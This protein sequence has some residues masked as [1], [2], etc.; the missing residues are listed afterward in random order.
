[1]PYSED[2][3]LKCLAGISDPLGPNDIV[4]AGRLASL[5]FNKG[6]LQVVLQIPPPE[7]EKFF[8][9]REQ[10]QTELSKLSLIHI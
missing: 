10:V 7:A 4:S 3:A 9:I 5:D 1:M 6:I 8:P 2:I